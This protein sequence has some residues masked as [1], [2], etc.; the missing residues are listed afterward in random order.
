MKIFSNYRNPN[1]L[2]FN[3]P[4]RDLFRPWKAT[5]TDTPYYGV[6]GINKIS[7]WKIVFACFIF[8]A[9]GVSLQVF[10]IR[11]SVTFRREHLDW[12]S[13]LNSTTHEKVREDAEKFGND[14]QLERIKGR[15]KKSYLDKD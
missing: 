14:E 6:K 2:N 13:S 3:S 9:I 1:T 10:A 15:L 11:H 4:T 7:N 5:K 12:S 8:A